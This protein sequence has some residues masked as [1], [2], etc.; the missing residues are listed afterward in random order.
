MHYNAGLA[1][2]YLTEAMIFRL[3]GQATRDLEALIMAMHLFESLND[4]LGIAR[5]YTE[6]GVSEHQQGDYNSARDHYTKALEL[7]KA[8]GN[9]WAKRQHFEGSVSWRLR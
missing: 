3:E 5:T 6:M 7:H 8:V 9:Q 1:E 4:S 2:A